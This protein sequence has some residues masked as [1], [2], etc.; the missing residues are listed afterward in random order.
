MIL[1][2][3]RSEWIKLRTVALT[4]VLATITI[5]LPL[6]VSLLTAFFQADDFGYDSVRMIDNIVGPL[7]L[8]AL[9]HA[10]L[11]ATTVTT[12]F[13]FNTIRPTFVA[14]PRRGTVVAAKAVVGAL[15][16]G[17]LTTAVVTVQ[18]VGSL[19][20]AD[21]QGAEVAVGDVPT[22]VPALVGAVVLAMLMALAGLGV[23][24]VVR[25]TPGAITLLLAWPLVGEGLVGGIIGAISD[26]DTVGRWLPFQAGFR[27]MQLE[28]FDG[29]SR[30][31][32]GLVF[33][34]TAAALFALGDWLVQRRD[35]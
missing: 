24:M 4:W 19:L 26:S 25:S 6:L 20:I 17:L 12:E 18:V 31:V 11:A 7:T 21:A 23:G 2:A 16:A 3:M 22:A 8:T 9:L 33:G 32:S 15:L 13:G 30:V 27:M 14:I 35:A 10:V 5:A 34:V 29:P 1:R 28:S